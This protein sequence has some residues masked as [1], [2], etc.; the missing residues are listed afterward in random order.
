MI[1]HYQ[2]CL[3]RMNDGNGALEMAGFGVHWPRYGSDSSNPIRQFRGQPVNHHGTH[4]HSRGVDSLLIDGNHGCQIFQYRLSK[5][6]IVHFAN[7][8]V[9]PSWLMRAA[10]PAKDTLLG[11]CR[12]CLF[13]KVFMYFSAFANEYAYTLFYIFF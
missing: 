5:M 8:G 9:R 2:V 10:V 6:N 11:Y 7:L 1:A 4:R 13:L 3:R 12:T